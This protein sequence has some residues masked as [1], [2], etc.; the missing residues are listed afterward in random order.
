LNK[1]NRQSIFVSPDGGETVYEQL[2]SGD[3]ILVEQSQRA[4]DEE[5]AYNE[6]EMIG[7]DA[8]ELRRKYP[9]LQKAWDKYRTVW[10][11]INGN[12]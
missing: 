1:K 5:A 8:I 6:A 11:L 7:A 3:R 9:T 2:P 10:H 4:K 12:D